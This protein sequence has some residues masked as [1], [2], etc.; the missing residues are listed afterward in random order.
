MCESGM[1]Y[2]ILVIFLWDHRLAQDHHQI[3]RFETLLTQNI[4]SW[5]VEAAMVPGLH[6]DVVWARKID[7]NTSGRFIRVQDIL[8]DLVV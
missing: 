7:P 5:S 2:F 4:L 6:A 1:Q 8:T 3:L